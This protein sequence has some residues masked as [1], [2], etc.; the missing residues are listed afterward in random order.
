MYI[1]GKIHK[2]DPTKEFGEKGFKKRLLVLENESKYNNLI[3]IY[4]INEKVDLL[5]GLNEGEIVKIDFFLGGREWNGKYFSEVTGDSIVNEKK[6][7]ILAE[8]TDIFDKRDQIKDDL[9]F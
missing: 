8:K 7:P 3:P 6:E 5:D 9:P 4:F 1:K 2:I